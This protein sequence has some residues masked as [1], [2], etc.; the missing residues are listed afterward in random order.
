MS[1]RFVLRPDPAILV[2]AGDDVTVALETCRP[3]VAEGHIDIVCSFSVKVEI[4]V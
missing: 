3:F 1:N 2:D 4:A